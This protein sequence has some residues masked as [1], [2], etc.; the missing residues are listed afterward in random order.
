MNKIHYSFFLGFALASTSLSIFAS[1][2]D[3]EIDRNDQSIPVA[4]S[5]ITPI[6]KFKQGYDTNVT[7]AKN[8]EISSWYTIFQPSVNLTN[9]FG[10]FGKHNFSLDWTFIHGAYHASS[11]DSYNDHDLSGKLNY[12][13]SSRHRLMFQGGYI[14][15]HEERGSRFSLGGGSLLD[16]PDTYEQLFGGVQYTFGELTA[17]ARLELEVGYLDNDYRSVF[18][19]ITEDIQYDTTAVRDRDTT[20]LGGTFYYKIGS[21]TD[22][23]LEAWNSDIVYDFT[24][25]PEDELASNENRIMLGTIWEATALTTGFAKIGYIQKDFKLESREDFDAVIWEVEVLW[26]PKTYSKVK[27]T[28]GQNANETN[29]EGFF[30]DDTNADIG[31]A[32]VIENTQY[33]IEWTHQWRERITSKLG[34]AISQDDYIATVGKIR[35][36]NNTAVTASLFYDMNYWL[37]FSFDY[38]YTDRDSTR[39]A[40]TYDRQLIS[41]GLRASIF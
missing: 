21:A 20:K 6:L 9:E 25:R 8:N 11:E 18:I 23:T 29:G 14:A 13:I 38:R 22:L 24:P 33:A 30:F 15:G 4:G 35:E 40:F 5:L 3:K 26:E 34:Y 2:Y 7:S 31:R 37:S 28:T 17:D 36:D 41:L 10:E 1:S 16:E 39:T 27:F 32:H 19:D 12:E